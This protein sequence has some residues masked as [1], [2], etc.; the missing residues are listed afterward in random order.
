VATSLTNGAL[1]VVRMQATQRDLVQ[2]AAQS[3]V[4][5]G[6]KL[7]GT[8]LTGLPPDREQYD[9]YTYDRTRTSDGSR[10]KHELQRHRARREAERRLR[11]QEKA[12]LKQA[13]T[14]GASEGGV[15]KRS[16]RSRT[17]RAAP[18]RD[19]RSQAAAARRLD[20]GAGDKSC[21]HR[22][23]LLGAVASG[24][25]LAAGALAAL[26]TLATAEIVARLGA[27]VAWSAD[28]ALTIE[29]VDA[30]A[31]TDQPLDCR[32]AG[33]AARLLLGLLAGRPGRWTLTGD[34]S[35]RRRPMER[36]TEPLRALGADITGGEP[37]PARRDR[38]PAARRAQR[39]RAALG[40]G[41][42]R[43]APGGSRGRRPAHRRAAR[44][45]ARP[46]RADAGGLRRARRRRARRG[47]RAPRPAARGEPLDPG[48]PLVGG[49]PRRG[50]AAAA[51]QR[52]LAARRRAVAA[53]HR[54][55]ARARARRRGRHGHAP[56]GRGRG[57]PRA[58]GAAREAD[59][60][61]RGD[62][63]ATGAEPSAFDIAPEDVPDL[64]DE[65]PILR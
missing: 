31:S 55:P 58:P 51:G 43:A 33:T 46:H 24:R 65:L 20:H 21:T 54:L 5:A 30:L 4:A 62:L 18:F 52:G 40:A 16:G 3:I 41:Q 39:R 27:S 37:A 60:D 36:V 6:G 29:G 56:R 9:Y 19:S 57:R 1:L 59:A 34:A 44:A 63:R 8:F 11:Q 50:R 64:V 17:S 22:A 45:H 42:E 28:G 10:S 26:D 14:E 23:L 47:D 13:R 25:T 49:L 53:A 12:Y 15:G 2:R 48:R 61:P 7:L 35:L 38:P 32:N